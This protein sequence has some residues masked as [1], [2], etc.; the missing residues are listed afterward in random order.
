MV[1]FFGRSRFHVGRV[2]VIGRARKDVSESARLE[3][4]IM[5]V[6]AQ[7]QGMTEVGEHVQSALSPIG[8]YASAKEGAATLKGKHAGK[9]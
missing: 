7:K 2:F 4:A 6:H 1:V 5:R 8:E 9:I 3:T